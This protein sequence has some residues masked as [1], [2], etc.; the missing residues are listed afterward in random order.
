MDQ[1]K[2]GSI[3]RSLRQKQGMTQSELAE[4]I[5]VSDKA[6]S[7]W[8][9]G[10]GAP[11]IS[12]LPKLSEAL[13]VNTESLLRGDLEEKDMSAQNMKRMNFYVCPDCGNL[14]FTADKADV[15]CCGNKLTALTAQTP[16]KEDCLKFEDSDGEWYITSGHE[17]SR[18]HY[19]SFIALL[20]DDMLILKKQYPEWGLSARLPKS[21]GTLLWYCTIHG[22]FGQ[23]LP[24]R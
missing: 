7:K 2:T 21:E 19:I 10:C 14:L 20:T 24:R 4:K 16:Q 6:V 13:K 17:M 9:R 12:L 22:L 1:I 3:I 23:R 8:E 5:G 18:E 15:S 11:D